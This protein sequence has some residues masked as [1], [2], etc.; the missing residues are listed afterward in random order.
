MSLPLSISSPSPLQPC[1]FFPL[2]CRLHP[3]SFEI[4]FQFPPSW[5]A[6]R[7]GEEVGNAMC[8]HWGNFFF[9]V[10]RF[11]FSPH[12]ILRLCEACFFETHLYLISWAGIFPIRLSG[13]V[14]QVRVRKFQFYHLTVSLATLPPAS[15]SPVWPLGRSIFCKKGQYS[16]FSTSFGNFPGEK[17]CTHRIRDILY[18]LC[19]GNC[20]W[21]IILLYV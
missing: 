18:P 4:P 11:A 3:F 9:A 6:G 8:V 1:N 12:C 14:R 13:K 5:E 19:N 7:G 17:K 21:A 15:P 20:D 16:R 10:G 2:I